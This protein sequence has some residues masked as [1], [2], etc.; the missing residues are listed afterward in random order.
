MADVFSGSY[1]LLKSDNFE[2]FLSELGNVSM[3]PCLRR[4]YTYY[5]VGVGVI[6]RKLFQAASPEITL[7]KDVD[8]WHVT[9]KIALGSKD[10]KFKM[11]E[12]FEDVSFNGDRVKSLIIQDGDKWTQVQTPFDSDKVTTI[13]REF[14]ERQFTAI[15]TVGDVTAVRIFSRL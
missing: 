11:G 3:E 12:E 7:K 8:E 14:G 6:K 10:T 4:A 5:I 13:V 9:T 1:K 15:M 2:E